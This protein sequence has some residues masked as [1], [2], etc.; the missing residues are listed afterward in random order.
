MSQT[1]TA[2]TE[3]PR[4]LLEIWEDRC[5]ISLEAHYQTAVR[6]DRRHRTLGMTLVVINAVVSTAVFSSMSSDGT[7]MGWKI[8][9]AAISV[10]ASVLASIQTFDKAGERAE[11]HRQVAAG[12]SIL[13]RKI[14]LFR[15]PANPPNDVQ[16]FLKTFDDEYCSLIRE[17]PTANETIYQKVRTRIKAERAD[18]KNRPDTPTQ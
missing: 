6:L 13:K 1:F 8:A 14:E 9:A 16:A 15:I 5:K 4:R 11:R 2:A 18:T 12:F 3:D 17:A 10:I 7:P